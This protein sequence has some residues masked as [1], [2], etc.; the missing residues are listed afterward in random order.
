MSEYN[1]KPLDPS[2][3][4]SRA[5]DLRSVLRSR[6][7]AQ[8]E[9]IDAIVGSLNLSYAG[10][11]NPRRPRQVL[12][13]CGPT[14]TGKTHLVRSLAFAMFGSEDHM[15]TVNCGAMS[16]TNDH[17]TGSMCLGAPAGY[18]DSEK[19]DQALL[20]PKYV[21][22]WRD[23]KPSEFD[24]PYPCII[25]FDEIEKASSALTELL[26]SL[27]ADGRVT[28]A[29]GTI[30]DLSQA[31][32]VFTSNIGGIEQAKAAS[33][34]N[35]GFVQRNGTD[36]ESVVIAAV[37]KRFTPEFIGR[38]DQTVVFKQLSREAVSQILVLELATAQKRII[39]SD[40]PF[41]VSITP[42]AKAFLLEK[43]Y[44]PVYGARAVTR[45]VEQFVLQPL[46]RLA[47]SEQ[48]TIGDL[49]FIG[50]H[51]N[52]LTFVLQPQ[53]GM[54]L[55][56]SKKPIPPVTEPIPVE[57][58]ISISECPKIKP[59]DRI[60]DWLIVVQSEK[61]IPSLEPCPP[62][63]VDPEAWFRRLPSCPVYPYV[64]SPEGK[65]SRRPDSLFS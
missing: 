48:V 16:E 49:V 57:R 61:D 36:T 27:T 33:A 12:L 26:L 42:E 37:A 10:L 54:V 19:G 22:R 45:I 60:G 20:S 30:S 1:L 21:H 13:L 50:V 35:L 14:G 29:D 7:I 39:A 41:V 17:F 31:I 40:T 51:E 28:L 18:R 44:S 3:L 65:D 58:P 25:L 59:N 43:S 34:G 8:D 38:I 6:V 53:G 23:L 4:G 32:I 62:D 47:V 24:R 11:A 52:E 64:G 2:K 9:A 63:G 5:E 15:V 56:G 46:A 55:V